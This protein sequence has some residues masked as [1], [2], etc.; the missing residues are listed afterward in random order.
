MN[1]KTDEKSLFT[2]AAEL[3]LIRKLNLILVFGD[4]AK[5]L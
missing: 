4:L 1:K 2:T 3:H 5:M